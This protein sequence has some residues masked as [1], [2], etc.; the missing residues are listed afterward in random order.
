VSAGV[1]L[2]AFAME[3][4]LIDAVA[5]RRYSDALEREAM[6]KSFWENK[7]FPITV[8]G[9]STG[10]VEVVHPL[11]AAIVQAEAHTERMS[12]PLVEKVKRPVGRPK[13]S[14]SAPDRDAGRPGILRSVK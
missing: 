14:E 5:E 12:R 7:G 9:G 13:G 3:R 4:E 11:I 8:L 6:L 1:V 2:Y 10:R